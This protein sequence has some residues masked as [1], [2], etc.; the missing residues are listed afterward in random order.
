MS[1]Y[2]I[3]RAELAAIH[4]AKKQLRLDDDTYRALLVGLTGLDSSA[5][6]NT[7]QR[8]LVIEHLRKKGFEKRPGA[9]AGP[10]KF[11]YLSDAQLRMVRGLWID[12][13]RAG[14]VRDSSELALN[15][16][17]KR[18]TG[19]ET[20]SWL[21]PEAA[22]KVIEALKSWSARAGVAE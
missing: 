9:G 13:A 2:T 6:M 18:M 20:L 4:V 19:I 22:N 8:R 10:S 5:K 21:T 11:V 12:L 1:R 17:V 15:H 3:R 14:A 7:Y 16:F